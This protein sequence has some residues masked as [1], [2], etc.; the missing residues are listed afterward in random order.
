ML[1]F[2]KQVIESVIAKEYDKLEPRLK[3]LLTDK[4]LEL[5]KEMFKE[6]TLDAND[7]EINE[8]IGEGIIIIIMIINN[9]EKG[10]QK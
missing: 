6:M 4:Q 2:S 9:R 3:R 7:I 8:E 10:K 5:Y 1:S